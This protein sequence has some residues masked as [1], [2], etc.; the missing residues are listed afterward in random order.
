MRIESLSLVDFR[1]FPQLKAEFSKGLNYIVGAN[2]EGK[3][4]LLEA[5]YYLSLARSFKKASDKDLIRIG[6]NEAQV[7]IS[8]L[9]DQNE[10]HSLEAHILEG[11][12]TILL[13]EEKQASVMKIVGKLLTVVYSPSS[14]SLFRGE[15]S[16]RRRFL[17]QSLS[18]ISP[19]YLYA[20]AR[21]KKLLK[22]RNNA[23]SL[24]YDDDVLSVITNELINVSYR[25]FLERKAFVRQADQLIGSIY[26][27]L[28]LTE[29]KVSLAYRSD[30]PDEN[31]QD[32]FIAQLKN[33]FE[34]KK[35]EERL[36]KTTLIGIQRDDLIAE[37]D[38]K[39]VY[40]Y[41]SQ[42]Q[43]RLVVLALTIASS[44][45]IQ[46]HFKDNPVLLLDDVMSD[47]DEKRRKAL[48]SYLHNQSGQVFITA[49]D[50]KEA[51]DGEAIFEIKDRQ[52]ERRK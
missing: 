12:K 48:L 37:L 39:E 38:G 14:V 3:T 42:G 2:A 27:Q 21:Y 10:K 18:L 22:E 46:D 5:I 26:D 17:D 35:S 11:G 16:E 40:A 4:N 25:I 41:A 1:N 20:L 45:I 33:L 43:N 36:R 13:D 15:P 24:N 31:I 7:L 32:N 29:E 8:Y 49:A 9:T 51:E 6:A 23:L 50:L 34:K 30:M 47:L 44:Q 19:K 28:F 52:I